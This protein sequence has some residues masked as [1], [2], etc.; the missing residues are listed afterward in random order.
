MID[1]LCSGN[2]CS[3]YRE[4]IVYGQNLVKDACLTW[5]ENNLML[6]TK[7]FSLLSD[8]D[9]LLMAKVLSSP[10]LFVLQVEMD[11]YTML[12]KWLFLRTS[13]TES[14]STVQCKTEKEAS[15][16]VRKHFREL[17]ALTNKPFLET[18]EGLPFKDAFFSVRFCNILRDFCCCLEVCTNFS[19]DLSN[20]VVIHV[21]LC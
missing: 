3:F 21:F 1:S 20:F 16:T 7:N 4:A 17:Y 11:I 6:Q 15:S 5:L 18:T 8:V 10:S 12:K 13:T 14:R 19:Y 9:P 2:I